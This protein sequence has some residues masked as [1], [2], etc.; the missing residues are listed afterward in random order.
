MSKSANVILGALLVLAGILIAAKSVTL[1]VGTMADPQSGFVPFCAGVAKRQL[2]GGRVFRQYTPSDNHRRDNVGLCVVLRNPGVYY[3][4][5]PACG[6]C[7]VLTGDEMVDGSSTGVDSCH[8]DLLPFQP[9]LGG[10]PP[11][12]YTGGLVMSE[13]GTWIS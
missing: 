8:R 3:R 12:R 5:G 1:H 6:I 4:Y 11:G 10:T 13:E 7:S 9:C 2:R